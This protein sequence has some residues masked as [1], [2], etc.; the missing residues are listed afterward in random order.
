MMFSILISILGG[1]TAAASLVLKIKPAS[2]K[3]FEKLVPYQG[4]IGLTLLCWGIYNAIML[5]KAL[6]QG[7]F[8]LISILTVV[9]MVNV[10][11][12][13]SLNLLLGSVLFS[14]SKEALIKGE[15]IRNKLAVYQG[16]FGLILFGLS[17]TMLVRFIQ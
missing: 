4:L 11:F 8:D 5:A 12:L 2:Q 1:L 14:K 9:V 15:L 3:F 16:V 10:G 7:F 17:I 13:L 6:S